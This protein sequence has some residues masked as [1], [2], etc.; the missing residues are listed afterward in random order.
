MSGNSKKGDKQRQLECLL[1]D[2]YEQVDTVYI[3]LEHNIKMSDEIEGYDALAV[4]G[5]DGTL[6]S[7][8]N[9]IKSTKMDLIYLP[10]G[11]LNDTAKSLCL[12]KKLSAEKRRIRLVDMGSVNE[13]MFAYVLAGGTFTPIG[14]RT[15]TK[16]KKRFKVLA[17]LFTVLREYKIRHIKATIKLDN[18][19]YS[20]EYTLIMALNCSR[21]FGFNF[22]KLFSHKDGKGQ[23]LLIKAP[24]GNGLIAKIKIF[25]PLFRVFFMKMREEKNGK[26][27]KFLNFGNLQITFEE[28]Q[29]FTIDGEQI[30]LEGTADINILKQKLKLVVF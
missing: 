26:I 16:T 6:N 11:T 22:N 3:D 14:Y 20:D 28:P 2:L 25:F 9:A 4:C 30:L 23:L 12:A 8:I 15:K 17:Y 10:T 5:G 29:T 27:M 21:C 1:K 7:A 18:K 24:K 19:I 13:T